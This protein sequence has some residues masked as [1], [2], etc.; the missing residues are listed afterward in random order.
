MAIKVIKADSRAWR[1][2]R[3]PPR[4]A[5]ASA[6]NHGWDSDP[7]ARQ[8]AISEGFQEGLEKGYQDGMAEG[9]EAG[10]R[11]G[12]EA[13]RQDGLRKGREE[14]RATGRQAFDEASAP[15]SAAVEAFGEYRQA[16]QRSRQK[17]LLEL[18]QKVARQVIRVELTLNP[19]QLLTLAEEALAAMPGEQGDVQILLNP[20]ECARIRELNPERAARWRLV[21]DERLALGECRVVTA[22]AE[23]D[24]GC[25]QRLDSCM[26]ALSTHLQDAD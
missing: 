22:Q 12:F 16:F 24:I 1:P 15:L 10:L 7:A 9:R 20:E 26:E 5:T 11:E 21:P 8:R 6:D 19:T 25:Q 18:V 13:G 14:G 3:F 23:A 17:E 2:Y 4:C